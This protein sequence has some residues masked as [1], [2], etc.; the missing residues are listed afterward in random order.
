MP[1]TINILYCYHGARFKVEAKSSISSLMKYNRDVAIS[2]I[3]PNGEVVEDEFEIANHVS[4]ISIEAQG[5]GYKVKSIC[6]HSRERFIF[7]DTDTR[8]VG[9]LGPL[10]EA[11]ARSPIVGV[12]EPLSNSFYHLEWL[13]R[14]PT[15]SVEMKILPEINTGV[16]AFNKLLLPGNFFEHW[17]NRHLELCRHNKSVSSGSIPDQPS[18][19]QAIVD[20]NVTP[21]L[22]GLEYNYRPYY[23]QTLYTSAKIIHAH[24][25][26]Q[27]AFKSGAGMENEIVSTFPWGVSI[28]RGSLVNRGLYSLYRKLCSLCKFRSPSRR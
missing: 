10:W 4:A 6:S 1:K 24:Q 14:P 22:I 12:V 16:L 7:L 13:N 17:M 15:W 26:S 5:Y 28:S 9:D 21:L 3:C 2:I 25:E 19:R 8:V 27:V 20:L 23:P 11:T 18:F